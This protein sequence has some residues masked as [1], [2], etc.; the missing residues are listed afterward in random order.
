MGKV[1]S[2]SDQHICAHVPP[3][4]GHSAVPSRIPHELCHTI[5]SG[6]ALNRARAEESVQGEDKALLFRECWILGGRS[7]PLLT[8]V[9]LASSV[10]P[11]SQCFW[12]DNTCTPIRVQRQGL[13]Q[14]SGL[15]S[16]QAHLCSSLPP[17]I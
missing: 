11:T 9:N 4:D 12:G 17:L 2:S 16:K 3:E 7:K 8:T 1:Y 5:T 14:A 15:S 6:F 13:R 10:Q